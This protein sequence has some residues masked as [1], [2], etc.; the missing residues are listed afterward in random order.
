LVFILDHQVGHADPHGVVDA[1]R[2]GFIAPFIYPKL[3]C[4]FRL[5][6][7]KSINVDGHKY[8][9][10]YAGARW[11]I[12][13]SKEDLPNELTF[14]LNFSKG[15]HALATLFPLFNLLQSFSQLIGVL[16]WVGSSQIIAQY[17]QL[18][19]LGYEVIAIYIYTLYCVVPIILVREM[20]KPNISVYHPPIHDMQGYKDVMQNYCNNAAVLREGIKKMGH[21]D[22]V[23]K[24]TGLPLVAFALKDSSWYMVFEVVE[25]LDCA[26]L[27]HARRRGAHGRDARRGCTDAW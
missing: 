10:V 22:V 11:V 13:R 18:I 8:D 9:L 2:K 17:Y 27:H 4:G 7:V 25:S 26:S 24:D 14:T 5:P 16:Y 12:W 15:V 6:L 3:E 20:K 23:S 21:F 19:R 1:T